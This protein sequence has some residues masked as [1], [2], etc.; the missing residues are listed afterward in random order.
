VT[1][2]AGEN[3]EDDS[4]DGRH[5]HRDRARRGR[6]L[7]ATPACRVRCAN[8]EILSSNEELQS[9]NE[10]LETAKEELQSVNEELQSVNEELSTVNEELETRN[11]ELTQLNNDL[12]NLLSSVNIPIVILDAGL[13]IRRFTPIAEKQL[14]LAQADVGRSINDIRL[15]I[16]IPDL[17]QLLDDAVETASVH[18]VEGQTHDGRW[19]SIRVQPYRTLENGVDGA[20]VAFID[21]DESKRGLKLAREARDYAQGIVDAD[22]PADT[23]ARPELRSCRRIRPF[24]T[25]SASGSTRRS[26]TCSTT[27]ATGSGAFRDCAPRS[28]ACAC[29][30]RGSRT[31]PSS[32]NSKRSARGASAS[33][34]GRSAPPQEPSRLFSR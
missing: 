8:E 12:S 19:Y 2:R 34:A 26:A 21:I 3:T 31:T 30:A 28:S 4:P 6:Q 32:T 23:R 24:S 16:R 5:P 13:H 10:E 7:R 1:G 29:A 22:S 27:S 9:T 14:K 25:R 20:L 18:E 11:R 33:A 15:S 17:R